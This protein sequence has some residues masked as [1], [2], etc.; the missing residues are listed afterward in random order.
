[1]RDLEGLPPEILLVPL[2]GHT[3]GHCGVAVQDAGGWLLLAGD[4]YV[5]HGEMDPAHPRCPPGVRA[6]QRM[7]EVDRTARLANQDRLRG[8]VRQHAG[9]VRV[10]CS[11]DKLELERC[12]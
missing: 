7:M 4:A 8:L 6:Y 5:F 11:H 12:G 10:V 2:V 1:M 3:R 9:S